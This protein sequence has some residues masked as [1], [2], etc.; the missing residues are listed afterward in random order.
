MISLNRYCYFSRTLYYFSKL[1]IKFINRGFGSEKGLQAC[2]FVKKRLPTKVFSCE[3]FV[4]FKTT[5]FYRKPLVAAS[6]ILTIFSDEGSFSLPNTNQTKWHVYWKS[7]QP[8][9]MQAIIL[10]SYLS[11]KYVAVISEIMLWSTWLIVQI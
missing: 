1:S 2:N 6:T 9:S 10:Q 7:L 8:H 3:L 11:D 5:F 4:I